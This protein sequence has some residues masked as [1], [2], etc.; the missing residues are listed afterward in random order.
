MKGSQLQ[1]IFI[2]FRSTIHQDKLVVFFS[3][4]CGKLVCQFFLNWNMNGI[5]IKS[6]SVQ[7]FFNPFHPMRMGMTNTDHSMASVHIKVLSTLVIPYIRTFGFYN[8]DVIQRIDVKKLHDC[9]YKL[10]AILEESR[11]PLI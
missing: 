1:S 6:N 11:I 5:G 2:C 8:G 9:W 4:E 3:T 10:L 7:L